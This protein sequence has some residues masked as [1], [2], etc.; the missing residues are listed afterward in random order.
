MPDHVHFFTSPCSET[1]SSLS[2]VVGK[3]KEW[4]AKRLL[5][6]L[7]AN[8]PLWQEEFFDHVLRSRES[9]SEKR[10]YVENNPVRA[11]MVVHAS[12]WPYAGSIHFG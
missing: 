6:H 9:Y 4:T 2:R 11:R 12:D 7:A 3:W 5:A 10:D 8:A 1:P